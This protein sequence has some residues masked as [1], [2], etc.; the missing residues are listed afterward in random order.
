MQAL[1]TARW[2][3][4]VKCLRAGAPL[5]ATVMMGGLLEALLLARINLELDKT[6]IFKAAAAPKDDQQRTRP[7]KEW[8]LKNY[9][10][11]AHDVGWITVSAKDVSEVLRDY[12]NY[13]H[14]SKQYSHNVV[15][16]LDDAAIL[17]EVAKAIARQILKPSQL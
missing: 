11:V 2:D 17:W 16:S 1:L 9:I 10:E 5:A 6:P 4:C 7:L 14:P 12:R 15:L 13:I 8:A 3:E